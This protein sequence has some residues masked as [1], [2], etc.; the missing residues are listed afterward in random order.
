MSQAEL[1]AAVAA[2][3]AIPTRRLISGVEDFTGGSVVEIR[4]FEV[5]GLV[6]YRIIVRHDN[7]QVGTIMVDAS[8]GRQVSADS[9]TGRQIALLAT[10]SSGTPQISNSGRGN[11]NNNGRGSS[12]G[13]GNGRDNSGNGNGGGGK[14]R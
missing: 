3:G 14:G 6:T 8:S 4:A 5:D 9:E 10:A 1:R 11:N 13:R 2:N 12:D 7:G